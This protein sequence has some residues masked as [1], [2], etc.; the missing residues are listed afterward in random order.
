MRTYTNRTYILSDKDD[1]LV[2]PHPHAAIRD[3][4]VCFGLPSEGTEVTIRF[5]PAHIPAVERLLEELRRCVP[6]AQPA[7]AEV[8]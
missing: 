8:A 7:Q 4:S 3:V 2:V 5:L 1:P 6:A